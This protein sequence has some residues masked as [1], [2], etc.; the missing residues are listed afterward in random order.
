MRTFQN[1]DVKGHLVKHEEIYTGY[2]RKITTI[3]RMITKTNLK[4]SKK[5]N[6]PFLGYMHRSFITLA[7]FSV[8]SIILRPLAQTAVLLMRLHRVV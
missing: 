5:H 7:Q 8:C 2:P 1:F 6:G 3:L 4:S